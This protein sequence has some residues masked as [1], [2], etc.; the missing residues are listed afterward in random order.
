[1]DYVECGQKRSHW[2]ILNAEAR[3]NWRGKP[4]PIGLIIILL[5][6][7]SHRNK[8]VIRSDKERALN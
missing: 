2:K 3:V 8:R 6:V 7:L 4:C 1:M 5:S